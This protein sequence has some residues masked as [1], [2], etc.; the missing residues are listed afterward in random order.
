MDGILVIDKPKSYTSFDVVAVMRKLC[1]EKK[2]G[3]T[4][5]LDPM[6]TGVLPILVGRAT[7]CVPFIDDTDKE[8]EA[9]FK[10]GLSTDTQDITGSVV[11]QTHHR[12]TKA[13][14]EAVLTQ[15]RGEIMQLPPMYS[16]VQVDG[17]RLYSLARQGIEIEREKRPV[18][19]YQCDLLEFNEE[20][21]EGRLLVMCSKGTYVRTLCSD[22]GQALGSLG[23]M[24]GLR[25]TVACGFSLQCALTLDQAREIVEKGGSMQDHLL[26]IEAVFAEDP[27]VMIT[28]AQKTRFCNGGPLSLERTRIPQTEWLEGR[29]YRVISQEEEFLGLGQVSC[30]NNELK[31]LRLFYGE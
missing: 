9:S 6:A 4:G 26:P 24:T 20:T 13:E 19:I 25:R 18:T 17:K 3:H 7:R 16:A 1:G 30:K 11:S 12:V 21:Q 14:I 27:K 5:T 2:I 31:I 15:F 29:T 22:I 28:D 8:Y 10:L 23:V